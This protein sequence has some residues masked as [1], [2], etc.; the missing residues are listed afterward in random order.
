[1]A[2]GAYSRKILFTNFE[3]FKSAVQK[4]RQFCYK[5]PIRGWRIVFSRFILVLRYCDFSVSLCQSIS[6]APSIVIL[7]VP[8]LPCISI[9]FEDFRATP[10]NKLP[11]FNTKILLFGA[12]LIK[13]GREVQRSQSL[14]SS[15]QRVLTTIPCY[16]AL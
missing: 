12:K 4:S 10:P 15:L 16:H 8:A 3:H 7:V 14:R 9:T 6:E 11:T 13:F 2:D 1:M 5:N